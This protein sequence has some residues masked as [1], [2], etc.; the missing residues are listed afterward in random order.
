MTKRPS[1]G[2][3][4][5]MLD[6][7]FKA[8]PDDPVLKD[9]K[10]P[11]TGLYNKTKSIYS[12]Q[13]KHAANLLQTDLANAKDTADYVRKVSVAA[14]KTAQQS[15]DRAK[16]T[17]KGLQAEINA[18]LARKGEHAAETRTLLR[19]LKHEERKN[20][21]SKAVKNGDTELLAA[22]LA[23]PPYL[24]GIDQMAA[25]HFRQQY[26]QNNNAQV[27]NRIEIIKGAVQLLDNAGQI[28]GTECGKIMHP[29]GLERAR[30]LEQA[31]QAASDAP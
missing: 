22:V 28:F 3:D 17:I 9:I 2:Q 12:A 1:A 24:S 16:S 25:D 11:F 7:H 31:A 6:S 23:A 8:L 4:P 15:I 14:L 21:L 27:L 19:E 5:T 18:P 30:K 13:E 29:K 26:H 20:F 10:V